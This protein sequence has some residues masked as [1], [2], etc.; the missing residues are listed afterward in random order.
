MGVLEVL[1]RYH[2]GN[3]FDGEA[4]QK[5]LAKMQAGLEVIHAVEA[6]VQEIGEVLDAHGEMSGDR[7]TEI[8]LMLGSSLQLISRDQ[9]AH[10]RKDRDKI[11]K[12]VV[13]TDITIKV[14]EALYGPVRF[15]I[16]FP[17]VHAYGY[18]EAESLISGAAVS[19]RIVGV[20]LEDNGFIDLDNVTTKNIHLSPRMLQDVG[21][22]GL[23]GSQPP[24]QGNGLR[25]V[26]DI[27]ARQ[28]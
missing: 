14:A 26:V 8:G 2:T 27:T 15:G 10:F 13:G 22:M 3:S 6:T 4:M 18:G 11:V 21:V 28:F 19:G 5:M 9:Q 20:G 7:K 12:P 23:F 25:T 17:Q 24:H 1:R 16:N